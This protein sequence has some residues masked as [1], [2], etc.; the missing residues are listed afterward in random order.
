M[1]FKEVEGVT[2]QPQ[3]QRNSVLNNK[4]NKKIS[5]FTSI[6][7]YNLLS[8]GLRPAGKANLQMQCIQD[9]ASV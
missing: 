7:F 6:T 1:K 3:F 2:L 4:T 5:S 9:T 8:A